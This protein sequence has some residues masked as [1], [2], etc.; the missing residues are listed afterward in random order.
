MRERKL[1]CNKSRR[2]TDIPSYCLEK[3]RA[4]WHLKF[5]LRLP[6]SGKIWPLIDASNFFTWMEFRINRAREI[7]L[8][9]P[10]TRITFSTS[11]TTYILR[12]P[13]LT[14][15]GVNTF[16]INYIIPPCNLKRF[17]GRRGEKGKNHCGHH[18]RKIPYDMP[19]GRKSELHFHTSARTEH[20]RLALI[21]SDWRRWTDLGDARAKEFHER[22]PY[23]IFVP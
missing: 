6:S 12:G 20:K 15:F 4:S 18:E 3:A 5:Y 10:G 17:M 16:W 21:V 8:S 7:Y 22:P 14:K 1:L 19:H 9:D 11:S 13:I 2:L 23:C